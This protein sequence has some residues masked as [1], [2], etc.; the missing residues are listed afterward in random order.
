MTYGPGANDA[1]MS[2]VA[3]QVVGRANTASVTLGGSLQA[4]SDKWNATTSHAVLR[5]AMGAGSP[6]DGTYQQME[7]DAGAYKPGSIEQM[8]DQIS[9]GSDDIS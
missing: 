9:Q 3:H 8:Q 1:F 2:G 7:R 5:T 4:D 6:D